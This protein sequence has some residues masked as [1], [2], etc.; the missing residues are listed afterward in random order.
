MT[1]A[2]GTTRQQLLGREKSAFADLSAVS[3]GAF[4]LH[5]NSLSHLPQPPLIP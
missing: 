3:L 5:E 4:E 2:F 1:A